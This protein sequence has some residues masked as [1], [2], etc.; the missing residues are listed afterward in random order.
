MKHSKRRKPFTARQQA[1]IL[2]L[3]LQQRLSTAETAKRLRF[4]VDP[5]IRFLRK[6]GVT[7]G[8]GRPRGTPTKISVAARQHLEG[9]LATTMDVVLARKYGVSRE[10]IRQI[11]QE[12][13]YPSSQVIRRAWTIRAQAERRKQEKLALELRRRQRRAKRLLAINR[14]SKRW[15]SGVL[16]AELAK[17]IGYTLRSMH[18]HIRRLRIQFPEKFPYRA[19]PRSLRLPAAVVKQQP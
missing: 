13:G 11:R 4:T 1:A 2:R 17:E 7:R 6:R 18:T 19:Q 9:E 12:L 3:Y 16:V 5:V 15:K 14:L 10:R 8:Q